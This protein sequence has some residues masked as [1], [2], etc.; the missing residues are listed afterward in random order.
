MSWKAILVPHDFSPSANHAAALARDVAKVHGA[1]IALVHV[2]DLP[3]QLAG[4]E[5][6]VPPETGA[7]IGIK[8][9]AIS[10]AESH[11]QDLAGR[12]AKDGVA[13]TSFVRIGH[14]VDEILR[15]AKDEHVDLIVMGT[16][17]RSGI[18]H[19]IAGSVTER[20]VR[21]ASVPVLSVRHPD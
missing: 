15:I 17:G 6:I 16:H 2:I 21:G 14:P 8:E 12:L 1:T 9:Y 5:V 13:T 4:G 18:R 11:L 3:H 19:L 20:V 7:P 10:S